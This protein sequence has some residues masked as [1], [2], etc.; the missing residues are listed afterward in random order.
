MLDTD[1][2]VYVIESDIN[3]IDA[4]IVGINQTEI[5]ELS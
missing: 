4:V 2:F 5:L 3:N 1:G